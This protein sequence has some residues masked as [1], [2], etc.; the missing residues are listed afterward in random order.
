[1]TN[2]KQQVAKAALSYIDDQIILGVGTG[3]TVDYF[4]AE[5]ATIKYR[6]DACVAS[7]IR[8]ANQLKAVG[9]PV[10]DLNVATEVALYIDGADEV[11][12]HYEMIKGGGR[13]FNSR[14]DYC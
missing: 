7:S 5:L 13:R 4:I 9:I 12:N 14:K 2:K 10:I 11:N 8:T 3:S 1:M 6:I